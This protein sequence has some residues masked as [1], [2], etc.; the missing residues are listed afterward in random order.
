MRAVQRCRRLASAPS[1]A[2]LGLW[3]FS[4][5]WDI[6]LDGSPYLTILFL[7]PHITTWMRNE[8]LTETFQSVAS[9]EGAEG[10]FLTKSLSF[11]K[12]HNAI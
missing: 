9:W 12:A 2:R 5:I 1:A 10:A 4:T 6:F 3:S 11:V 7:G 8:L